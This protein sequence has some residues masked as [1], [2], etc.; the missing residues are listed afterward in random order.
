M[1]SPPGK[2]DPMPV[3][4]LSKRTLRLLE[5]ARYVNLATVS[6]E[7][8][9]WVAT[10][11][12]AWFGHPLRLVFGSPDQALH[13]RNI[14]GC[15]RVSGALFTAPYGSGLDVDAVDGAQFSG[16]CREIDPQGLDEYHQA[17]YE[18]VFTDE[19]ERAQWM[20]PPASLQGSAPHRLYLVEVEQLWLID[21]RVWEQDRI[22]R[23]VEV[24]LAEL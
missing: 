16:H 13:S 6:G 17:F 11:E 7:G 4:E 8:H 5:R 12:Y 19:T 24:P 1:S 10:L 21:T 2:L 9:P 15:S 18:A 14:V 22:D 20:L 23:R 3:E